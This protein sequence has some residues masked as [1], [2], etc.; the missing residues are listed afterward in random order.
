MVRI[1]LGLP[2]DFIHL[3][4]ISLMVVDQCGEM[5]GSESFYPYLMPFIVLGFV[6]SVFGIVFYRMTKRDGDSHGATGSIIIIITG[7]LV[8]LVFGLFY[9][10]I[11]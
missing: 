7:I 1:H 9:R 2:F 6:L 5:R 10:N 11:A 4:F 8:M 3:W